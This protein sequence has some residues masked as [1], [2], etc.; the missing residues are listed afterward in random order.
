M[1]QREQYRTHPPPVTLEAEA[2]EI[3]AALRD[4]PDQLYHARQV[5][6]QYRS[7]VRDAK[8]DLS[9]AEMNA[10]LAAG[11]AIA[12]KNAEERKQRKE[13][14]LSQN[15][16]VQ[17]A[18]R[19]LD[20]AEDSLTDA[21]INTQKLTDVFNA[22]RNIARITASLLVYVKGEDNDER[23]GNDKWES[24]NGTIIWPGRGLRSRRTG[25][26]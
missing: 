3:I 20:I 10:L 1:E 4:L 7:Q 24:G 25:S 2:R 17:A 26:Q 6:A 21:T 13:I 23:D 22:Y 11:D 18:K 9:M 8:E 14:Y 12:G 15:A 16:D 5:E 19:D